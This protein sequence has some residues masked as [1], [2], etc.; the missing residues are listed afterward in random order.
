MRQIAN[1]IFVS[2]QIS[3]DHVAALAEAGYTTI[4]CNRPD[5]ESPGQPTAEQIRA[6]A[7]RHGV[8]FHHIPI[9]HSG[10]T[11]ETVDAMHKALS[12]AGG[13]VLAYCRSGARS[14]HICTFAR[15]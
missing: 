5:H 14:A 6:E 12:D 3:P 9:G 4:I 8:T 11:R 10:I 2:A 15:P 13:L 7:A 1:G